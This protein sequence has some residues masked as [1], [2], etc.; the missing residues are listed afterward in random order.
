MS[1]TATTPINLIATLESYLSP[2][3]TITPSFTTP[4]DPT[5]PA[6][7]LLSGP[8]LAK[9]R[10]V[11]PA[12]IKDMRL[13]FHHSRQI[14]SHIPISASPQACARFNDALYMAVRLNT[15][16]FSGLALLPGGQGE[17]RDAARELQRCVSK[18]RFVGGVVGLKRG[19]GAEG[20]VSDGGLEEVWSTAVKY[21]V[22]IILRE[23]WPS[24]AEILDYQRNLPDSTLSPLLTQIHT[25]HS[26]SPLPFLHLYL[27][28]VFDRH[29][30]LRLILSHPGTLPS[31]LPRIENLLSNIPAT[32]KPKRSYLDVWQ[33]N[34]YLST[35]DV[36]EM[37]SMRA[38]LE[39]IPLDR[40]LY[41]SNYP[42]EE[43]GKA[44]MEELK[45]SGFLTL[46]EWERVAW[47]NAEA[48]FGLKKKDGEGEEEKGKS[49]LGMSGFV[50]SYSGS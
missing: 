23:L 25:S 8:T 28:G 13:I 27:S 34:I 50:V 44:L 30:S 32:D 21:R 42:L 3:L 7:H 22:P 16:K 33:H 17:G 4:A 12:R 35:T 20:I 10:N 18:Y 48:V 24:N 46:A 43:R 39:Q 40:V 2:S 29:P 47:G 14:I 38:L 36:Q 37:S 31:L 5:L 26:V 19:Q 1:T 49:E 15:D 11:G 9:L 41:A 6:L 45:E